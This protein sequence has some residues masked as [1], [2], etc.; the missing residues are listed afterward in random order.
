MKESPYRFFCNSPSIIYPRLPDKWKLVPLRRICTVNPLRSR[1]DFDDEKEVVFLPMRSISTNGHVDYS[2]LR[3]EHEVRTGFTY[4][5]KH[6]LL[7]AK[8]TPCFENKKIALLDL[9]PSEYGYGSTEY[10]VIRTGMSIDRK[11]LLCVFRSEE[12]ML[13]GEK[14]MIG[15]AGQKRVPSNFIENYPIPYPTIEEQKQ[16]SLFLDHKKHVINKYIRIKKKQIELLKELKQVIINDAVTGKIDVRTGKPYPKYKDSGIEWLGKI[17]EGWNTIALSKV[18]KLIVDGTHFSPASS[19][20]GDYLYV[21]AKNIKE[22]GVDLSNISYISKEAHDSIYLRCPVK[23]GDVLYIKDGATAGIATVN[24]LECEFSLLSSVALISTQDC[25]DSTF[26]VMFLNSTVFKSYLNTVI[27]G[28]AMTR[29][30]IDKLKR[31]PIITP[32]QENQEAI[33]QY[34]HNHIQRINENIQSL[35]KSISLKTELQTR[36]TSDVVTGKLDVRGVEIPDYEEALEVFDDELTE[37]CN[38]EDGTNA[39]D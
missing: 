18:S 16:I 12:F 21:T 26:L 24:D 28:G 22:Y 27:S 19:D 3:K 37:E 10:H 8:I 23:R 32:D 38:E 6:D 34:L 20:S 30:T 13:H 9:M 4:F 2:L 1:Q 5:M 11:F 14:S 31:F 39:A 7:I 29:F 15:S 36:L 35:N 25:L 17:P 33:V